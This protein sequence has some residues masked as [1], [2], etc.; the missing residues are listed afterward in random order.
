MA[1]TDAT[2]ILKQLLDQYGLGGMA[3]WAWDQSTNGIPTSAIMQDLTTT[4]QFKARFPGIGA[5]EKA[6]LPPI[7]P[8]EYISYEDQMKQMEN[9]FQLPA[10]SLTDP[11]AIGNWIGKDVSPAELTSRV[12]SGYAAVAYAPEA[13]RQSFTQMFGANGDGALAHFFLDP[14]KSTELLTQQAT[15]AQISGQASMGGIN[16]DTNHAMQLAQM[17]QT[18]SSVGSSLAH[19]QQQASLYNASINEQP[20]LAAGTQ[21]IEAEMGLSPTSQQQ[22]VQREQTRQASFQG[23]GQAFS[24]QYG[25]GGTGAARPR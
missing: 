17:G 4:P 12:Q 14:A 15:A 3:Q 20:N 2:A 7:S 10:G 19:L 6:G 23:G 24:D 21:G 16:M 1:A 5:R 11:A 13:V 9:R 8:G 22:V 25:A 18:G